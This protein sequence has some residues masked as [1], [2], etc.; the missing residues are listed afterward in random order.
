MLHSPLDSVTFQTC[1]ME[2]IRQFL[3][4]P[5][6]TV[7]TSCADAVL[8]PNFAGNPTVATLLFGTPDAWDNDTGT[9][10]QSSQRASAAEREAALAWLERLRSTRVGL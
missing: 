2:L 7:D 9:Q 4:D 1:G 5:H 8:E 3:T 6:E 10:S